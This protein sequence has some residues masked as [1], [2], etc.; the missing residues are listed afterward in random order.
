MTLSE[1]KMV[2]TRIIC[3][4]YRTLTLEPSK[5]VIEN[6]GTLWRTIKVYS[7]FKNQ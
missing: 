1:K 6:S 3:P 4:V 5:K 7:L 2:P